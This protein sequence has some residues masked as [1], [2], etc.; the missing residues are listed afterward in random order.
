MNVVFGLLLPSVGDSA[1]FVEKGF[2]ALLGVIFLLLKLG[3]RLVTRR[4]A[5][6]EFD[7]RDAAAWFG[8]DIATLSLSLW[9]GLRLH[10]K[11]KLSYERTVINYFILISV[12]LFAA[13]SYS[14]YLRYSSAGGRISGR[15]RALVAGVAWSFAGLAAGFWSFVETVRQL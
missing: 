9:I 14:Q 15:L 12:V 7:G 1:A 2:A 5:N 13:L 10:A 4:I 3:I 11:L 8:V 6:R